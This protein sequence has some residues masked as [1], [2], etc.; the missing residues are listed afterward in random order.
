MDHVCRSARP[1]ARSRRSPRLQ[2]GSADRLDELGTASLDIR[3]R[4]PHQP[5]DFLVPG[6]AQDG[7]RYP[8]IVFRFPLIAAGL[9]EV[10]TALAALTSED[11]PLAIS[12][13]SRS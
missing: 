8:R 10:A 7:V 4:L 13:P 12:A 6:A 9:P 3:S 5:G 2:L 11:H 1:S